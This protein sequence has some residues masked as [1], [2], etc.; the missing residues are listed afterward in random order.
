MTISKKSF[1]WK[2]KNVAV[3]N[4]GER[5]MK[6]RE[7]FGVWSVKWREEFIGRGSNRLHLS[8]GTSS[9]QLPAAAAASARIFPRGN[10]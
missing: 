10:I 9:A 2:L 7:E 6:K 8:E 5:K 1:L 3:V 4:K